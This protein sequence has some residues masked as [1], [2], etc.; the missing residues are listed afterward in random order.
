MLPSWQVAHVGG[1]TPAG[2]TRTSKYIHIIQLIDETP[3]NWLTKYHFSKIHLLNVI[4][5]LLYNCVYAPPFK[6]KNTQYCKQQIF[7]KYVYYE[8]SKSSGL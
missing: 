6:R 7:Y 5:Y 2:N 3:I 4:I 1:G 8:S